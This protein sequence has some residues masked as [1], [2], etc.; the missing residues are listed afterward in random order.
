MTSFIFPTACLIIQTIIL[1]L[2]VRSATQADNRRRTAK[3]YYDNIPDSDQAPVSYNAIL[4]SA[5]YAAVQGEYR[6]PNGTT[7]TLTI[8]TFPYILGDQEDMDFAYRNALE[9]LE[10]LN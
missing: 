5:G 3:F 7:V 8:K 6:N 4:C 2:A 1:C 10:I 9:L